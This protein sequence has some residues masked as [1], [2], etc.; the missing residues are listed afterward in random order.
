MEDWHNFGPSYDKTLMAWFQNFNCNWPK[1]KGD[2]S[3]R[4]YRMWK[5]YLLSC[6]GAFRSREIQLWQVV[7]SKGGVLGGHTTV[8]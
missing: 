5:Y 6:A 8:R 3:D 7:L 2:H 4:F 1:I